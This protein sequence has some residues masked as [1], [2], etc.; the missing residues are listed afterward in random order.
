MLKHDV[1]YNREHS[2]KEEL[3]SYLPKY[4]RDILEMKANNTFAGYTLDRMAM[5]MEETVKDR[6]FDSCSETM[7]ERYESFLHIFPAQGVSIEDRRSMVKMKWNGGGKMT[8]SRIKAIVK[9]CCGADCDV[10]FGSSQLVVDMT[11]RD[12]PAGYMAM[13]REAI[14]NSTIPSHIEI[15][16]KGNVD[17]SIIFLWNSEIDI[18]RINFWMDFS[19]NYASAYFDGSVHWDGTHRF[20][21]AYLWF[22]VGC[23]VPSILETKEDYVVESKVPITIEEQLSMDNNV[24]LCSDNICSE[25][26]TVSLFNSLDTDYAEEIE[27]SVEIRKNLHYFDGSVCWNGSVLMNSYIK[28]EEL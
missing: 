9:E 19:M 1:F 26:A 15:I 8:G 28:K 14:T 13:I 25:E 17:L 10:T 21:G 12:D 4:W 23:Q 20:N 11:F 3:D 24:L 27:T 22:L 7:L 2:G 18:P 6:F 16:F 5:D